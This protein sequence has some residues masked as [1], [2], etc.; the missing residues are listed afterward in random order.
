MVNDS[1]LEQVYILRRLN[2]YQQNQLGLVVLHSATCAHNLQVCKW[3]LGVKLKEWE[4]DIVEEKRSVRWPNMLSVAQSGVACCWYSMN[5][6]MLDCHYHHRAN[7][8]HEKPKHGPSTN[9]S[10]TEY[11]SLW[12]MA[13]A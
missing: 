5:A 12:G 7:H 13:A 6:D 10:R 2:Q 3:H 1:S 8:A 11:G 4:S 9:K